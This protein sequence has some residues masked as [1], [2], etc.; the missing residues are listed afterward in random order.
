MDVDQ[1]ELTCPFRHRF[2]QGGLCGDRVGTWPAKAKRAGP[3]GNQ[4][5]AGV[6]VAARK[7]RYVVPE[8]HKFV[9]EPGDDAFGAAVEFGRNALRERGNLCNTHETFHL[10]VGTEGG[11]ITAPCVYRV[12]AN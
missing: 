8:L 9:D 7:Q 5:R 1:V 2:E 12:K 10:L 6:G 4:F 3:G 11:V